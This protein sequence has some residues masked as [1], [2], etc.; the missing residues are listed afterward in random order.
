MATT[1]NH[2]KY[3]AGVPLND[4]LAALKAGLQP[5]FGMLTQLAT[6][7]EP[8]AVTELEHELIRAEHLA[9]L[10]LRQGPAWPVLQKLLEKAILAHTK[11]AIALSQDDPWE[12]PKNWPRCG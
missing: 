8:H 5:D 2:E 7:A 6:P 1:S 9:L 3:L 10:E 12:W 11:A 4:E